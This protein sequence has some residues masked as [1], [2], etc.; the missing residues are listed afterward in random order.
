[1]KTYATVHDAY[2]GTLAD[3]FDNPDYVAAPRGLVTREKL[4]YVFSIQ[5][6]TCDFIKTK[7]DQRNRIIESYSKKE[8]E[9]YD[10]GS[11]K[12]SDFAAASK[13]WD[14]IKNPDGTINSAYGHLIWKNESHGNPRFEQALK[15]VDEPGAG[16]VLKYVGLKRTPWEWAKTCLIQDANTRQAVLRFSLPEHQ[17][18]GNKDQTCTMHGLFLIRDG[19]LH[20][21]VNM[22]AN[23]LVLGLVYD[24]PWFISLMYRMRDEVDSALKIGTYTHFVHSLHLYEKDA[25]K[26]LQM[27]GRRL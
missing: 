1:M 24:L 3:V 17:W 21:T 25:D 6:P 7:S 2:L 8:F 15:L 14:T 9:L 20:F 23:D 13:F 26:V 27:L 10:S 22:R 12:A 11:N 16:Q 4:N 19:T 18:L 5:A